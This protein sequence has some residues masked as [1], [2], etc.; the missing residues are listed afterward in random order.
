VNNAGAGDWTTT[1]RATEQDLEQ[2]FAANIY[3]AVFMT[4]AVIPYMPPGG[5]IV[6]VSSINGQ[7]GSARTP[8]YNAEKAAVDRLAI[9][10]ASEFGK[11]HGITVNSIAPGP[12]ATDMSAALQ[13]DL[14]IRANLL[15]GTKAAN[16]LGTHEDIADA[17]LLIVSEKARWITGQIIPVSG[18]LS[19]P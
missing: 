18:G 4:Q 9:S 16:R 6:N 5:R 7:G 19:L 15:A 3:T 14:Q 17:V 1:L 12:V 8:L 2:M 13:E 10:W 11:S